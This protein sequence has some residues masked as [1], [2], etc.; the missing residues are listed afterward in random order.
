MLPK[1]RIIAN[2]E[3][4]LKLS[5]FGPYGQV[6]EKSGGMPLVLPFV[7][8]YDLIDEF[9]DE[10]DGIFFTGGVDI[11]PAYYNEQTKQTCGNIQKKRDELEFEVFKRAYAKDKP[12][13]AICR[14]CQLVNVA[15]GGTLYQ[16]IPTEYQ[17]NMVHAQTA[18]RFSPSHPIFIKE[19][20][21]LAKLV[22]INSMTGNS[23]HHQA[24]KELGDGLVV[25]AYA[26]DGIIEAVYAKDKSY[27]RAYQWHPER[28]YAYEDNKILFDDFISACKR[29]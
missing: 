2:I 27:L 22:G 18:D 9:I 24:I 8:S 23:F 17:T 7:E 26:E 11:S 20:S 15:L 12:I 6:I 3:D 25:M 21:P 10:C 5:M 19:N 13:L 29:G 14:G 4:D 16:D 1:I 28:L